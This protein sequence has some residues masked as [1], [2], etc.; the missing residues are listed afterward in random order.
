MS[1]TQ[2]KANLAS[3]IG[4]WLRDILMYIKS[5]IKKAPKNNPPS[6]ITLSPVKLTFDAAGN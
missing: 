1:K 6:E 5:L 3:R 4:S 2:E